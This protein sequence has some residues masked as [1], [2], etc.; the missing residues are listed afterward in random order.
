MSTMAQNVVYAHS[1]YTSA[2]PLMYWYLATLVVNQRPKKG[3][4]LLAIVSLHQLDY[5]SFL[6]TTYVASYTENI[7]TALLEYLNPD[8]SIRVPIIDA[9]YRARLSITDTDSFR[10]AKSLHNFFHRGYSP[11]SPL[12]LVSSVTLAQ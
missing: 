12:P 3:H 5:I 7:V 9:I 6:I 11:P 8:C 4:Y 1:V 2:T 10:G